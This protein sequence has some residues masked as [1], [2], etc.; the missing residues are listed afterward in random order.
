MNKSAEQIAT[1]AA[2]SIASR[3]RYSTKSIIKTAA[4][5]NFLLQSDHDECVAL[6]EA[7]M[8][9]L[10]AMASS[11]SQWENDCHDILAALGITVT[12]ENHDN[13]GA[14]AL[15]RIAAL[16]HV[17][18]ELAAYGDCTCDRTPLQRIADTPVEY[19]CV[20][21]IAARVMGIN[22]KIAITKLDEHNLADFLS[23]VPAPA[24]L[25]DLNL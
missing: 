20:Y 1:E 2:R 5:Q 21:C 4:R 10:T 19:D 9:P 24:S 7:C 13:V 17:S 3:V 25:T 14:I 15:Q 6:A 8:E 12:P 22:D 11:G 23:E 18:T 16:K